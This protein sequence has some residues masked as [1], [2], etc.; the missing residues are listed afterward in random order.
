[1]PNTSQS[2]IRNR[3]PHCCSGSERS[4]LQVQTRYAVAWSGSQGRVDFALVDLENSP[5]LEMRLRAAPAWT[6]RRSGCVS[7][8]LCLPRLTSVFMAS[9]TPTSHSR[10][11]Q[12]RRG[13]GLCRVCSPWSL[14]LSL[15]RSGKDFI[16]MDVSTPVSPHPAA[17]AKLLNSGKDAGGFAIR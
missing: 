12:G 8:Q 17:Y 1:M 7:G 15:R 13:I 6:L 5:V 2:L 4:P 10:H 3:H 16:K 11:E 9:C 14:T